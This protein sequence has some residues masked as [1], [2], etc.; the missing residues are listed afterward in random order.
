MEMK[1]AVTFGTPNCNV[2][3]LSSYLSIDK[4]VNVKSNVPIVSEEPPKKK[5]GRKKKEE[6]TN[7]V[8]ISTDL[9]P[10]NTSS[11]NTVSMTPEGFEPYKQGYSETDTVLK[12]AIV[13]LDQVNADIDADLANIRAAKTL[14]KKYD[15]ISNLVCAKSSII[16]SKIAAARELNSSTTKAYELE[17][18]RTKE[19]NLN[20]QEV[21]DDKMIMDMYTSMISM[22]YGGNANTPVLPTTGMGTYQDSPMYHAN[23]GDADEGYKNYVNNLTPEQNLYRYEDNPNVKEVILF[24]PES[25]GKRFAWMDLSTN[26]EVPNLPTT[27]DFLMENFYLDIAQ[28]IAKSSTLGKTMPIIT[29]SNVLN[30]Y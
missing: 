30:K 16:Q 24:D 22:P 28:G 14:N 17:L 25:G 2:D 29:V 6:T 20:K 23:V 13:Q 11:N 3:G 1:Q 18:K 26:T 19:L 5:R 27:P 10:A 12:T 7:E 8:I 15:Y 4:K 9:Q 21:N